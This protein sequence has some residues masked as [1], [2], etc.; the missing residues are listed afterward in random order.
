MSWF[1]R[2]AH[3][4]GIEARL[5]CAPQYQ[6]FLVE[7]GEAP[8]GS[9]GGCLGGKSVCFVSHRGDV[10]PCGYLPLIAGNIRSQNLRE[11]WEGAEL[12]QKLRNPDNAAGA[13]HEPTPTRVII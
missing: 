2:R 9:P 7:K 1:Y 6:R 10:F 8:S 12:F 11:I 5:T 3:R 4:T 13:G